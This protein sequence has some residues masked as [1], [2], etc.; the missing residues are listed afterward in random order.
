MNAADTYNGWKNYATWCVNLWLDNDENTHLDTLTM[1]R[2]AESTY[3]LAN[4]LRGYVEDLP[5]AAAVL[6]TASFASDLLGAALADVDWFTIAE[7]LIEEAR[8]N[9]EVT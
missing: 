2:D 6:E 9:G 1:A 5:V 8:E 7:H 3:A 4:R